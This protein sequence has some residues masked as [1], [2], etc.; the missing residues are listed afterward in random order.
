[1]IGCSDTSRTLAA[2]DVYCSD[3]VQSRK[4]PARNTP[5]TTTSAICA[6]PS[7]QDTATGVAKHPRSEQDRGHPHAQPDDRRCIIVRPP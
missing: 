2:I 1:M 7:G 5:L 4:C 6:A 3:A